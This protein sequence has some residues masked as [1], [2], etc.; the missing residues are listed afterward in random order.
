[1]QKCC[2]VSQCCWSKK[3]ILQTKLEWKACF[4]N[5]NIWT[6]CYNHMWLLWCGLALFPRFLNSFSGWLC[7]ELARVFKRESMHAYVWILKIFLLHT[8][9]C[10]FFSKLMRGGGVSNCTARSYRC[11]KSAVARGLGL[12][13]LWHVCT[14]RPQKQNQTEN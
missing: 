3:Y 9:S 8:P 13:V 12:A 5:Q 2:V 11:V 7:R 6:R 1:M 14:G 10:N 4:T